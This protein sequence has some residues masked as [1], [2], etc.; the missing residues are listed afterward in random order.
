GG[1]LMIHIW[2]GLFV[3]LGVARGQWIIVENLQGLSLYFTLLGAIINIIGNI[4]LIPRSGINGAALATLISYCTSV[5]IAP[6]LFTKTR[7][8]CYM[9]LK[10]ILLYRRR[11]IYEKSNN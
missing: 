5:I 11:K 10:S 3:S 7:K 2:A 4:L 9:L 8:S 1:V 6:L